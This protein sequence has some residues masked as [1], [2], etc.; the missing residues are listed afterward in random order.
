M[1]FKEWEPIYKEI[2]CDFGWRRESD[3]QAARLLSR[4][5][6]GKSIDITELRDRIKGKDV[7]VCGNAPTLSQDLEKTDVKRYMII[8]ADGATSTLLEKG[9]VPDIIVTDLDGDIP[10]E[11][12]ASRRGAIMV[13]HAHG[14][15]IDK[16][17]IV[18]ELSNVI[19]TTQSK[20]LSNIYN[21]GGFS[22]GDRCVFLAHAFGARNITLIGFYF[23][24]ENVTEMKKK[25]LRWARKLIGMIPGVI[26]RSSVAD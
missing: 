1:N 25:K 8:A 26:N 24:D 19:G 5:L 6:S 11:I 3:E 16:L 20:P 7:L 4:L 14:D 22:D 17:N 10:D 12:E 15:N 2:L 23:E 18:K 13:V 9:I 21:F